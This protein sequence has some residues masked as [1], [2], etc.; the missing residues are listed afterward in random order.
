MWKRPASEF[1]SVSAFGFDAGFDDK[2]QLWLYPR[3]RVGQKIEVY[4]RPLA[5][6]LVK[7]K[8]AGRVNVDESWNTERVLVLDA[9]PDEEIKDPQSMIWRVT[10]D[11]SF[12][13]PKLC[14]GMFKEEFLKYAKLHDATSFASSAFFN[15]LFNA[16]MSNVFLQWKVQENV[17]E[18]PPQWM[19]DMASS[20]S[21][22]N[23]K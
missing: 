9:D 20:S 3:I 15:S 6:A 14:K 13:D 22:K 21:K 1:Y 8:I 12:F 19:I 23:C 4:R 11:V 7:I 16:L 2:D 5:M 18:T 10:Q 17:T